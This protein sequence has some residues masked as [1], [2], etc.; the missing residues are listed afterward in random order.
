[1]TNSINQKMIISNLVGEF[2]K[3]QKQKKN[4]VKQGGNDNF[5]ND[6]VQCP[7]IFCSRTLL[8]VSQIKSAT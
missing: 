1:M 5:Q 4:R 7:T 8:V 6:I 2:K 3:K